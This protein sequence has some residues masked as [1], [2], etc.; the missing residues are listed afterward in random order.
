MALD[1]FANLKASIKKRSHRDDVSDDDL[2]DY[3]N[4]AE[5]EFY[6]NNIA[7]L[8]TRAMEARATASTSTTV[9]FLALPDRFLQM[10]RLKLNEPFTGGADYDLEYLAPEQMPLLNLTQTPTY[11]SVTTQLE[12]DTIPDQA[13]TTEMQYIQKIVALDDTNSTNTLLT[14]FPNI[15]LFGGLWALYQ[16]K[17]EPDQAEYYYNKFMGS[18][19]GANATDQAGRYGS[20]PYIRQEGYLP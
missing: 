4:Q 13:Y 6:N 17:D 8:R 12:F 16:D 18:I 1:N 3:I 15:Y 11:F 7:P 9:R 19:A 5:S 14:D 2:V 20:A 10:R